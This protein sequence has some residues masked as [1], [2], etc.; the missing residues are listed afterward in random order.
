MGTQSAKIAMSALI[1]GREYQFNGATET[2]T[3]MRDGIMQDQCALSKLGVKDVEDELF[4]VERNDDGKVISKKLNI[5]KF[6]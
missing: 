4:D 2:A 6:S 1:P 3:Q 5:S